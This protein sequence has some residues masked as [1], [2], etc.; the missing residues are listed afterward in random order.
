MDDQG[1]ARKSRGGVRATQFSL[2]RLFASTALVAGGLAIVV[3]LS[4]YQ[5][6]VRPSLRDI[7]TALLWLCGG[8]M[9]GAG[10]LLPFRRTTLGL[11]L[12]F[13]VQ[14]LLLAVAFLGVYL[15]I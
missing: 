13:V 9:I 3:S 8:M 7:I 12:G 6:D 4:T 14:F 5:Y 10:L 1:T 11:V 2:K 15:T